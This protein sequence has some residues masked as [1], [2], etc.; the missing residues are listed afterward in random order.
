MFIKTEPAGFFMYTVHL[1]YDLEKPDS[2]DQVIREYLIEH[3]LEPKYQSTGE[4]EGS[5]CES[6][7]FGGC[8]LGK[9][10]QKIGEIQRHAVETEVLTEEIQKHLG[11]AFSES[12]PR[13]ENLLPQ[14]VPQLVQEFHPDSV[15]QTND[16]G[17][18]VVSLDEQVVL[19]AARH[20]MAASEPS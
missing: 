15:F 17:E 4:F 9:H 2:E 1:I 11:S 12:L 6:M 20:I 14:I 18:L 8:Y 16:L 10:L 5:I 7:Q 19:E 13:N 3:E